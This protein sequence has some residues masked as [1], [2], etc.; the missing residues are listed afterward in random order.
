MKVIVIFWISCIGLNFAMKR[1]NLVS[2]AQI[3]IDNIPLEDEL[4]KKRMAAPKGRD[5]VRKLRK[6]YEDERKNKKAALLKILKENPGAVEVKCDKNGNPL[7]MLAENPHPEQTLD[8]NDNERMEKFREWF[9]EKNK[10]FEKNEEMLKKF[11]SYGISEKKE[12]KRGFTKLTE[13]E[14]NKLEKILAS[15]LEHRKFEGKISKKEVE[16]FKNLIS[17]HRESSHSHT[18]G[19]PISLLALELSKEKK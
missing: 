2:Q 12:L 5:N 6:Y 14:L 10:N 13:I 4:K 1:D 18:T 16:L 3:F 9:L 17:E 8:I 15:Q 11:L 19:C 7:T